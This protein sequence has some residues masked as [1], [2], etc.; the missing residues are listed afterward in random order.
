[1]I[2]DV[3]VIAPHQNFL[4]KFDDYLTLSTPVKSGDSNSKSAANEVQSVVKWT[5]VHRMQLNF[6]KT[7]EMLN[8][9]S[10]KA[11]PVPMAFIE[12]KPSLNGYW[13]LHFRPDP[14]NWDL[15][16][17]NILSTAISRL[18]SLLVSKFYGL[19][20]PDHRHRLFISL[21]LPI[22]TY[23]MEVW[24]CANY[25]KYLSRIDRLFKIAFKPGY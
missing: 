3:K 21:I 4:V 23:A 24:G 2:N 13:V 7:W 10:T 9:K 6:K 18:Y 11:L 14:C 1:M 19:P 15:H 17:D 22:F 8:C 12:R 5:T 20:L 16:L 25:H